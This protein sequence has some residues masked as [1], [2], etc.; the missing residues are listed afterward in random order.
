MF[1]LNFLSRMTFRGDCPQNTKARHMFRSV[2]FGVI[3]FQLICLF[4][5]IKTGNIILVV[6]PNLLLAAVLIAMSKIRMNRKQDAA[7]DRRL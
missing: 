1:N 2:M 7:G 6:I 3:L 5:F 4:F